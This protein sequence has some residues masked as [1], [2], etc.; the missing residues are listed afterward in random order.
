LARKGEQ[1]SECGDILPSESYNLVAFVSGANY[2]P[3]D[4][5]FLVPSLRK[6]EA[7][8]FHLNTGE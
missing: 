2:K 5:V 6:T 7:L 4:H 3:V 8:P 1:I